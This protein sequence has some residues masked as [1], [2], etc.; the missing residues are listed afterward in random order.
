M[1]D[2]LGLVPTYVIDYPVATQP[3]RLRAAAG[4]LGTSGRCTIGAHLHPWVNP[5]FNEAV[6]AANSFTCNLP[7]E[8]FSAPS[9]S[10]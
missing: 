6:T 5:P 7:V 1:F 3:E 8:R 4:D 2:R 9:C 10:A